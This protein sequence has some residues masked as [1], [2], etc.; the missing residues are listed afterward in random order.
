MPSGSREMALS[1]VKGPAIALII[2]ASIGIAFYTFQGLLTLL[3]GGAMMRQTMPPNIPE[4]W[5]P[6]FEGMRGPMAGV[7]SFIFAAVNGFILFGAIKMTRLQ[8]HSL[9]IATCVVAMLP[10]GC[11]CVLGL[12]FAIWGL[13]VLNKPEVKSQFN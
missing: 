5:R 11:C 7:F 13:V 3:H 4:Q 12:P 9:A 2:V 8:S 10:C 1:A 6:F